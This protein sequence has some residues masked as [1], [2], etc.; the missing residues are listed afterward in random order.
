MSGAVVFDRKSFILTFGLTPS[1]REQLDAFAKEKAFS[2][3]ACAD[4]QELK[5]KIDQ[6]KHCLGVF[7]RPEGAAEMEATKSAIVLCEKNWVEYRIF[8]LDSS[9]QERFRVAPDARLDEYLSQYLKELFPDKLKELGLFAIRNIFK[10]MLPDLKAEWVLQDVNPKFENKNHDLVI[11][12]EISAENFAGGIT[13]RSTFEEL[14]GKSATLRELD[15]DSIIHYMAEISNQVLGVIS[16][17]LKNLNIEGR[18]GLPV[19]VSKEGVPHYKRRT[20][21]YM[22][23]VVISDNESKLF[24]ALHFLVP[25]LKGSGFSHDF[26]FTV[27]GASDQD[28]VEV[29]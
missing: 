11:F 2:T 19:L 23:S 17:N 3:Y 12:C 24:F 13:V 29:L 18:I 20:A 15:S 10:E 22:P 8:S 1:Q 26:N 21:F 6:V 25:Y 7:I 27:Q 14:K 4:L 9:I 5:A 28:A 16:Y